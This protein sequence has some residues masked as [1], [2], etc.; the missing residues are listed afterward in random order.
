MS[1]SRAI[2]AL[3][4]L[5]AFLASPAT[6]AVY[7]PGPRDYYVNYSA[8]RDEPRPADPRALQVDRKYS[9]G[10]PAAARVLAQRES[11]AISTGRNPA[12]FVRPRSA[13]MLT[14]LVEFDEKAR[15]D[16]SGFR[17]PRT[18]NADPGDCVTEPSGTFLSGPAHNRIPAPPR[19][20]NNTFWVRDFAADHYTRLLY[21]DRGLTQRVRTDL[22]DP[23]D[24]RAGI[25]VSG[26]TM[27]RMYQEM[28]KGAY[29]ITGAAVGWL[30]V[31]HSEAWYGAA[32]CG[33]APQ[34]MSGHP[35]NPLGA[36]QLAIDAVDALA[37]AQPRFPWASY[38]VEDVTDADGDGNF[39][40]P[41]GVLDHV[42]LVHAGKDKSADGGAQGTYAIW[43]NSS[44]VPGGHP[45][46]GTRTRL[47][48]Y[49]LQPEDAGVGVF[50]HEYGH[51]LGLPDLYD[52]TGTSSTDVDFWD[53]M[54][55]GSHAG[56]LYQSMPS[57]MG[58]WDKWILGW[59]NPKVLNPGDAARLV[60]VGQS[61]RT[62]RFTQDGIKVNLTS[63][64][65]KMIDP[66]GGRR[67]WW[68]GTGQDL[69]DLGLQ[70]DLAVPAG[71][72]V[73]FWMWDNY[74]MEQDYDFGYVEASTD[75][76]ATWT[77]LPV[78]DSTGSPVAI[79]GSTPGW[80]RDYVP[81]TPY[82][83]RTVKLRLRY[84]TDDSTTLRGWHA[85]DFALTSGQDVVWS[86]DAERGANGWRGGWALNDGT[87]AISRFYL[88]EWRNFDG[89]DKGLRYA[90]DTS[91]TKGGVWKVEKVRYN[92]PG[93][94]VWYRDST[95]T[96]NVLLTGLGD[97]P[98]MGP[99][100]GLLLVDAHFDPL[101]RTDGTI[102]D[103]RAQ[104][105][106]AA[107][108]PAPTY[109][110]KECLE[111]LCTS[112]KALK[113]V[114]SF[115]DAQTWYPGFEAG[116]DGIGYR[117]FDASVVVPAAQP[118]STRVVHRD[119]TPAT[120]LYGTELGDGHVLGTG[121]PTRPLGVRFKVISPLPGNVG[122]VVS[123]TPPL[124]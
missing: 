107:F 78:F 18:I 116:P 79:T 23:R 43:A 28:S 32:A 94:L 34:D 75:G 7:L 5:A 9:G 64:P 12:A 36:S 105:S 61:S 17:R 25:D 92:A 39:N 95:Y 90:Y 10:S 106:N 6:P 24:G 68:S 35:N 86:D 14:L 40:E 11:Q 48:T 99:K 117:D 42:V 122:A 118:Y 47:F 27:K 70:R 93:L 69:A 37:K 26:Y 41:D 2:P 124:R 81:L 59:A 121:N 100:G 3:G 120:E 33:A 4:L 103:G 49:T 101:R 52:P 45:I 82:A 65:L 58:L 115:T 63:A 51:D 57:H 21:T 88:A 114:P 1:I 67:A 8:P 16:F 60:T 15:D 119:G 87:R 22:R 53:L 76:G 13:R 123:V 20:D 72:D 104:S 74:E 71:T 19:G 85:D 110:F 55:S 56:L 44:A 66:H 97:P 98:S 84:V 108:S 62:P 113:G 29:T 38:D 46:P 91:S 111:A 30:R 77:R 112:I 89:F 83:G 102:L 50:A 73:R 80:R 31:P 96:S 109:P 54:A